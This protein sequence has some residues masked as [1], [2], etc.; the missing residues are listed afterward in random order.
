MLRETPVGL[1]RYDF[2]PE[3]W[4]PP[5]DTEAEL[6]GW[7]KTKMPEA[8]EKKVR[9]APNEILLNLFEELAL[10]PETY[11]NCADMRYVLTLLLIRR[12]LFRYEREETNAN[13]QKMLVVYAIKE[14]VTHEVPV[15]LPDQ[16]RLEKVQAELAELLYE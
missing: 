5:T 15:A 11:P 3:H 1:R 10:Q 13:G 14:N 16:E 2:A 4:T 12:R 7:W 6:V 8:K 9:L